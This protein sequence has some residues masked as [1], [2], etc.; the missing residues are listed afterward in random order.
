MLPPSPQPIDPNTIDLLDLAARLR[1]E[2]AL[3]YP[4]DLPPKTSG[5]AIVEAVDGT[6]IDGL[7]RYLSPDQVANNAARLSSR[8]H[9]QGLLDFAPLTRIAVALS[10]W[11][12]CLCMAKCLRS[13]TSDGT[14]YTAEMRTGGYLFLKATWESEEKLGDP[15]VRYGVTLACD[16]ETQRGNAVVDDW[17]PKDSP[18]WS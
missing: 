16:F 4:V 6:F 13:V 5:V 7:I 18:Y 2:H 17:V 1:N 3:K 14:S 9:G 10:V 8:L 11:H 15:W 12:G